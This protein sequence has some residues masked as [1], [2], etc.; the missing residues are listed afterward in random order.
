MTS[1]AFKDLK[2]KVA[3]VAGGAKNLGALVATDLAG[4]GADVFIHY[5]DSKS[6]AQAQELMDKLK[7]MGRRTGFV[8][9]DLD[10]PAV[11]E[12]LFTECKSQLG[13]VDVAVNTVGQV[14]KKP[15]LDIKPDEVQSMFNS[16]AISAFYFIQSAG[17]HLEDGGK[18]VTLSTTLLAALTPAY[19]LYQ[20]SKAPVDYYTRAAAK[21]FGARGI[22]VNSV[23]PGPM[24]TPFFYGQETPESVA[25]LKSAS[26]NGELTKIEDIAPIIRF[27]V[28][29]GWWITAQTLFANGGMATR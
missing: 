9:G 26:I 23:N 13:R 24:D 4:L 20:A 21:E 5:H 14:L 8:T 2:G 18:I 16:N 15:I 10:D 19:S 29:E 22:S 12:K 17:R 6:D 3:V 27:L 11:A 28:T 7:K 25:Y 1:Y